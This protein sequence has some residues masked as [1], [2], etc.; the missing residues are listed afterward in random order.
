[1]KDVLDYQDLV[2]GVQAELQDIMEEVIQDLLE[3][4]QEQALRMKWVTLPDEIKERIR[5]E[6]PDTFSAI[7][8]KVTNV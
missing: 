4:I 2:L 5:K 1:M 3:P 8:R 6:M 7:T